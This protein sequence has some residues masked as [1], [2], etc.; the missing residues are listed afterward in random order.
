MKV[1][2][3]GETLS[4]RDQELTLLR[5]G[6]PEQVWMNLD[7]SPVLDETGRPAGVIAIVIETSD[8]VLTERRAATERERQR[9]MMQQMPGFAAVLHG[10]DFIYEFVN[11]AYVAISGRSEFLGR[12]FKEVFPDIAE[13]GFFELLDRVWQTGE[14]V[15]MRG[16]EIRLHG[17]AEPQYIDF[18]FEPIRD[19]NGDTSGIFVG[20]YEVTN[21]YRGQAVLKASESRLRLL[22]EI[23]RETAP[24]KDADA[25][26]AVTTRLV[27]EHLGV[28][29]CAYA[30]MDEDQDGFTIRG[31]W[32]APG[33]SSIVG[34]YSLAAFGRQAVGNLRAGLPL[35][36]ADNLKELAPE[37]AAT[38]QNIGIAA[39]ICMPLIKQGRLTA[40]MAIHDR[41][42]RRWTE[43]E[44]TLMREVTERSWAHIQRIAAEAE[45]RASENNL[46]NLARAMPNQAWTA[47]PSGM[48]NWFNAQV[49]AYSGAVRGSLDGADWTTLVHPDDLTEAAERWRHAVATGETYEVEFR[50][51]RHDGVWRW[52]IARAVPLRNEQGQVVRWIGTNTDIQDQ[53]DVAETL[54]QR[55]RE[56]TDELLQAQGALRQ[57]QKMEAV[58]QLTGG[59]AHDFNNLLMG[60]SGSLELI[61][62]RISEGRLA[63]IERYIDGAQGSARRA[64]ALTQ[65]LLAFSR[66]QTLDPKPTDVNRLVQGLEDLIRRTIGTDI[67]LEVV[68]AGGLWT[69]LIDPSQLEN[70]LLN[71]CINARDAMMPE[72][73]RL[74]IETANKWLDEREARARDLPPGQYVSLCVTDTGTG[75]TPAVAERA[76][77]PFFTTK[78]L[79]QGTGLGLS[80]I[81][82]FVR[83]SGGQVRIYSELGQGTTM[84]L[85]LPRHSGAANEAEIAAVEQAS[86][87]HG[88]TVL[89]ID[90]E[91]LVRALVVE[92]LQEQGYRVFEAED[93]PSGLRILHSS[94]KIDLLI[95][96]VGLP[97]GMNGRQVADA[98]RG[99]RPD[100]KILFIT[101]YAENAVVGN[102]HL[103][104]GM[105][106]ITKP[107]V[108]TTLANKVRELIDG[109]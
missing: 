103:D 20:G 25:I 94:E 109:Q 60:I 66:R 1:V 50:L 99:K 104:P 26:L 92:V 56:R 34:H 54:E 65:R 36:V 69:T 73:G 106:V 97:G 72:G 79:G 47:G 55:V 41:V 58:G 78:P 77:D 46:R 96:D 74:T 35:V 28:A 15:V 108:T 75:M 17:A 64:A 85:Y 101:G 62:R 29:I 98:A 3:A 14:A 61:E 90:D 51:R 5:S 21:A 13:Q 42:P 6:R 57:A 68:G 82:G 32:T 48:L 80:M 93:G 107:F 9:R 53:K 49:Y 12:G 44:L 95:T 88:E 27:G 8:R 70:S 33:S 2:L 30:D 59:I 18:V 84:C 67:D 19:E 52:H 37:E 4:Y 39:T 89:V 76:F 91:E 102:G 31:D 71:L 16:M 43:D 11:D 24:S 87:G 100:L 86:P 45:L 81:Y 7:Y 63:G 83:Q 10:P 105:H 40:L 38:F 23:A 22:D